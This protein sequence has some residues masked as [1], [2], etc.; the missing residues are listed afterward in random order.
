[1]FNEEF[2]KEKIEEFV[3]ICEEYLDNCDRS[4]EE[5]RMI[6][7]MVK[8]DFEEVLKVGVEEFVRRMI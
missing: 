6:G 3:S 4:E 7:E 8:K 1:M 5:Y 2:K